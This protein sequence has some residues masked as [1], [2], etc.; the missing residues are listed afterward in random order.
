MLFLLFLQSSEGMN[1]RAS[2]RKAHNK[3][4]NWSTEDSNKFIASVEGYGYCG[5][6]SLFCNLKPHY[7][8]FI[9]FLNTDILKIL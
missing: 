5:S 1:E 9:E 7:C 8:A 6:D 2:R 4:C 3:A